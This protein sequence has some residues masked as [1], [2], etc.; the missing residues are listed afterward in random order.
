MFIIKIWTNC[1]ISDW[2]GDPGRTGVEKSAKQ[3]KTR[4]GAEMAAKYYTMKYKKYRPYM[5]PEIYERIR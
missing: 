4:L 5:E 3:Y 1:W 2:S